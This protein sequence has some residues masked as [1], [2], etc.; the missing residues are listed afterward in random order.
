MHH[1]IV[2]LEATCCE[3]NEFQR[4]KMEIIE[5][6]A[7]MLDGNGVQLG[8]FQSFVRPVYNPVLTDFCKNLTGISQEFVDHAPLF[9]SIIDDFYRWVYSFDQ[10]IGV[11]LESWGDFDKNILNREMRDKLNFADC[12]TYS[13]LTAIHINLKEKFARDNRCKPM[14]VSRA[15][16]KLGLTFIGNH[17]R[18]LDDALNIKRIAYGE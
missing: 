9:N 1:V 12:M 13:N 7:V 11:I 16:S 17:H 6:G 15:L 2:D 5:I 3:N 4:N 8:T 10:N 18:A 14:G